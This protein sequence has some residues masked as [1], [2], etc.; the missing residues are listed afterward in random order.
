MSLK[1][2][3]G[4][5]LDMAARGEFEVIAHGCNCFH[6]M[7]SGIAGQIRKRIPLAYQ[8]DLGT[9]KG[10]EEK[11]GTC[12]FANVPLPRQREVRVFNAYTQY[13]PG[14]DFRMDA[15]VAAMAHIRKYT[16][17]SDTIGLPRIG[18][19][20]GGGD[21]QEIEDAIADIFHDRD[22]TVVSWRPA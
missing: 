8:A 15:F 3:R 21:W 1:I 4:D 17:P 14:P 7:G 6:A 13:N 11:L 16:I 20:I 19:G 9:V 22:V 5:L 18:A 10:S 12:S 2:V